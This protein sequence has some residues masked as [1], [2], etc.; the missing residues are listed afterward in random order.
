[1][2]IDL[3]GG[4][5]DRGEDSSL[6]SEINE[7]AVNMEAKSVDRFAIQEGRQR[8]EACLAAANAA[9][10]E[11]DFEGVRSEC[12]KVLTRGDVSPQCRSYVHLRI[13]QSYE[14]GGN[15]AQAKAVY[16]GIKNNADYPDVHRWEA[17]ECIKEI[18]RAEQGLVGRDVAESRTQIAAMNPSVEYFVSPGGNDANAGT[19][20]EPFA[21]LGRA[22]D[23][24]RAL[25]KE[26]LPKGGVA[27]DAAR[28]GV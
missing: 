14:A 10:G 22:R 12:E 23:A 1:M 4:L 2:F 20:A 5:A 3:W 21:M 28:W 15:V 11:G 19:S 6:S 13:A 18:D 7:G 17:E 27:V 24:V 9:W 16:E 8:V 26:G 25:K